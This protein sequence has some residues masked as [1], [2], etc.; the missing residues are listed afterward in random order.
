MRKRE[1][2][3][4][5]ISPYTW[6]LSRHPDFMS[7]FIHPVR[8]E[9]VR[10]LELKQGDRVLDVGCGTG[11]S[12]PYLVQAVGNAGEVVGVEI[13]PAMATEARKRVANNGWS[14]IRVLQESA[15]TVKLTGRFDG[16]LLFGV[17][18]VVT[19]PPALDHL[20]PYLKDGARIVTFGAK[21]LPGCK[22]VVFNPFFSLFTRKLLLSSTAPID[23]QPWRLLEERVGKMHSEVYAGGLMYLAWRIVHTIDT[24][25]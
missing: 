24:S 19:S 13:S 9:A 11:P 20:L 15:Q 23:D 1:T 12:F 8:Q 14:N 10:Y 2:E 18:E 16:L 6:F 22:G 3:K 25:I 4:P 17:Q 21:L 5:T 7:S